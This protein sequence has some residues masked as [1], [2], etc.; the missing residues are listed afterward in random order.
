M[1]REE[2]ERAVN[3]I[4]HLKFMASHLEDVV[5]SDLAIIGALT[6][7]EKALRGPIPDP[8]TGLVNCGCGH[9]PQRLIPDMALMEP[10]KVW[11]EECRVGACGETQKIADMNWNRA[12]GYKEEV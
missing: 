5:L 10:Y 12:H 1:K 8:E 7:A 11:D 9:K 4:C 6:L 2:R 3:M